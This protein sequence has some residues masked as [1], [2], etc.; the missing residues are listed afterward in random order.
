MKIYLSYRERV[1]GFFILA[2]VMLIT[3]FVFGAAVENLWFTPKDIFHVHVV[4]GDGLGKGSPVLLSGVE[5][6][7]LGNLKI[8]KDGR[9]DVELKIQK[10]HSHRITSATRAEIRRAMGIGEKRVL[11]YVPVDH[12][13]ARALPLRANAV[14]PADEPRDLLDVVATLD[15]GKYLD[16]LD[17]AVS[18]L[19]LLLQKFDE[20]DRMARMVEA[21]DK[22][23]PTLD[24]MQSFFSEIQQPMVDLISDPAMRNAFKGGAKLFNDPKTRKLIHSLAKTLEPERL[25]S[26]LTKSD[27]LITSLD[28]LLEADGHMQRTL[29]GS[30]RLM[31]DGKLEATLASIQKLTTDKKLEKLLQN[32]S[33]LSVQMA[34]IGPEIP[35]MTKELNATMRELSIVLK[36]LQKTWLLDEEAAEV[37][38]DMKKHKK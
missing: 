21:F 6:G 36:A 17:R 18:S 35:S 11:L 5:I 22:L 2:T 7:N 8:M 30:D 10:K 28:T 9:V 26:L 37:I 12:D 4:R 14:I 25:D 19:D 32:M 1:A 16:T 13:D 38:K 24:I 3:A 20:E 15:L 23:G 27:R 34:K 33:V 29:A 31:N